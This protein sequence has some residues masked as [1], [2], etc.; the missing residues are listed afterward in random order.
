M[1]TTCAGATIPGAAEGLVRLRGSITGAPAVTLPSAGV[2]AGA[3]AGMGAGAGGAAIAVGNAATGAALLSTSWLPNLLRKKLPYAVDTGAS[4]GTT[5]SAA[6]ATIDPASIS[7]SSAPFDK[8]RFAPAKS[9]WP[10]AD[11]VPAALE[12]T[13]G[14]LILK[15]FNRVAALTATTAGTAFRAILP[16]AFPVA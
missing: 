7:V 12:S 15:S 5:A 13:D 16:S 2:L 11:K 14:S 6:F 9:P 10:I 3:T 4:P 8:L 1:R